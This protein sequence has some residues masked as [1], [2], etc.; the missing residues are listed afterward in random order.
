MSCILFGCGRTFFVFYSVALDLVLACGLAF[1]NMALCSLEGQV[2]I[3]LPP[4]K[5]LFSLIITWTFACRRFVR[6]PD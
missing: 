1:K 3:R 5:V 2:Y 6:V 4:E